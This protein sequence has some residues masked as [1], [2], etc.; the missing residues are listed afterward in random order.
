MSI[1]SL[2]TPRAEPDAALLDP[3]LAF[4]IGCLIPLQNRRFVDQGSCRR[5]SWA[6]LPGRR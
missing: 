6:A 5:A 1:A 4:A 2:F 3:A